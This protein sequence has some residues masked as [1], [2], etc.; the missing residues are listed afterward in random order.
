MKR[1]VPLLVCVAA[2]CALA[3][4][5]CTNGQDPPPTSVAAESSKAPAPLPTIPLSPQE[6]HERAAAADYE[7]FIE[8]FNNYY[9]TH[10]NQAGRDMDIRMD[11][12]PDANIAVAPTGQDLGDFTA[13]MAEQSGGEWRQE[14][15]ITIRSPRTVQY[16]PDPYGNMKDTIVLEVCYDASDVRY[17]GADGSELVRGRAAFVA[18]VTMQNARQPVGWPEPDWS[19]IDPDDPS[20]WT[21]LWQITHQANDLDRPCP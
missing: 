6:A 21:D 17:V 5:G 15:R 19:Q 4:T 12:N 16:T 14:G 7:T 20:G 3:V 8:A 2:V 11:L 13:Q 10:D 9:T 1:Q 18:T